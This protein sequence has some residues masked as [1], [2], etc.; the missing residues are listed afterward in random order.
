MPRNTIDERHK[1]FSSKPTGKQPRQRP[2][3][4][5]QMYRTFMLHTPA[6]TKEEV[7]VEF[8]IGMLRWNT[9]I[10]HRVRYHLR[11][12]CIIGR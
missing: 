11:Y 10:A 9:S 1:V 8:L 6:R 7:W 3:K 5:R 2:R 12:V 4:M